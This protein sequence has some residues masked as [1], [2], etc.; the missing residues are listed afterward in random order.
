M[1]LAADGITVGYGDKLVIADLDL[2]VPQGKM[3]MI[4]GP[5]ACGK[6]TL[7]RTLARLLKPARGAVLLDGKD[8]HDLP[9]RQVAQRLGLLPQLPLAP[10]GIT[11]ADLVA[12]GRT[13]HQSFL[14]RWSDEDEAAAI[15]AMAATE[16]LELARRSVDSL[17][18]GQRQRVWIAMALAQE[19]DLLLL[20]EP[21]TFLDLAHQIEILDLLR[22]LNETDGRT[23]VL[24]L[25]DLNLA[26]RYADNIVA[27]RDGRIVQ[28]GAPQDVVTAANVEAV[29]GL[30]CVVVPDPVVGSPLIV[31]LASARTGR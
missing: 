29:F 2:A 23:M 21:T 6:S 16:T 25:H 15:A 17:S 26:A 31:P 11:V 24:V 12:R 20:D 4:I 10:D 30:A 5:N 13:P 22:H 19:T 14:R 1:P 9:T 8:I 7:L 3:T 27:M 18:G 28:Q